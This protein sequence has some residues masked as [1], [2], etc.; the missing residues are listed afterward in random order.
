MK[1]GFT[2]VELTAV[3]IIVGMISIIGI[4]SLNRRVNQ[5]KDEISEAMQN[6]IN[7][8]ADIYMDYN[9]EN[10][11]KIEGNIYCIKLRD[12]VDMDILQSPITDPVTKNVVSEDKY[13]KVEIG[14]NYTIVSACTEK[15]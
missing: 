6:I 4:A 7:A 2:L 1:K 11:R 14:N 12:L 13:V 10:Y 15:R 9:P 8:S 5:K 3:I